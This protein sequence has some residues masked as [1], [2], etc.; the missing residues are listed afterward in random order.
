[1]YQWEAESEAERLFLDGEVE[2]GH[3]GVQEGGEML[4]RGG[5]GGV[6]SE[7]EWGVVGFTLDQVLP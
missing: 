7:E 6:T 1:M 2:F 4:E 3:E 5:V